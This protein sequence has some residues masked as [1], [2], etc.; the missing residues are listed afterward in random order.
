[1]SPASTPSGASMTSAEILGEGRQV[2]TMST[3]SVSSRGVAALFSVLPSFLASLFEPRLRYSGMSLSYGVAA[4]VVGGVSP[5]L[6]GALYVWA[7]ATWPIA[8]LLIL[9]SLISAISILL[10][11]SPDVIRRSEVAVAPVG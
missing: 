1:L 9:A 11:S 7:K 2:I 5:L 3:S 6:S 8:L 10:S 4:G